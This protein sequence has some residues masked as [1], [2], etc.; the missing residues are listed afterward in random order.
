[1]RQ[2][3]EVIVIDDPDQACEIYNEC[4]KRGLQPMIYN[5]NRWGVRIDEGLMDSDAPRP[6]PFPVGEYEDDKEG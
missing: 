5:V 4:V 6:Y 3:I 2:K 1:M